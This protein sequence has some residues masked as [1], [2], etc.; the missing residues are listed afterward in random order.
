MAKVPTDAKVS[1]RE[2]AF[3]DA[4]R[5]LFGEGDRKTRWI[6][7]ADALGAMHASAPGDDEAATLYAVALVGN[8]Y[9]ERYLDNH[10]PGFG[11]FARAGAIALDVLARSPDHP[12]AAHYVIHAF[13]DPEH[14]ILALPAARRYALIAPE[15][16]H[17]R[18]MPSHIF[19]QL[20]MWPEAIQSNEA[21]WTASDDWVV[22]KKLDASHHDFH[23]L[24]WLQSI[25]LE[26]NQRARALE[27][28]GRA[29][30]SLEVSPESRGFVR[31][32]Y[33]RMV[34]DYLTETDDWDRFDALLAPIREPEPVLTGLVAEDAGAT[35][36]PK[37]KFLASVAH[38]EATTIS[39]TTGLRALAQGD[40]AGAEKAADDMARAA[41][42]ADGP[43]DSELR[44]GLQRR[45][46]ELRGRL[47]ALRGDEK[48]AVAKLQEAVALDERRPPSGPVQGVTSRERLGD[49]YLAAG[50]PAEALTAYRRVLELH[51]RRGRALAAAVRAATAAK[52]PSVAQLQT[53]LDTVRAQADM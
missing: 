25:Y 4:A 7:Y 46:L 34:A 26:Q 35:C 44:D 48:A 23:S 6:G 30:A 47:A 20:G 11:P 16:S 12:G 14:A 49:L 29:R 32:V 41:A 22:R 3:L 17:A 50:Q 13:D 24:S 2:H 27:V 1:P 19:V 10:D 37:A 39:W 21:A 51:P 42:A 31:L 33:A 8:A 9:A 40:R 18:H 5:V 53:E 52:D 28:L 15:A 45:E 36:H 43:D 38:A